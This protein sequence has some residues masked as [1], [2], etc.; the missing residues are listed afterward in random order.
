MISIVII[1]VATALTLSPATGARRDSR[2]STPRTS[3]H[4]F[5]V[6]DMLAM[7]RISDPQVSPDGG[8]IVFVRRTTDLKANRGRTDLWLVNTGGTGLRRFTSDPSG[9][10][11]PRWSPDGKS[12]LFISTR[13]G[14]SQVW[15]IPADGGEAEQVTDEP[16]DVESL[17]VS[18]D[19]THIA[20]SMQVF[21]DAP[22]IEATKQRLDEIA[23][24]SST[25]RLY[26][27]LFVRHWDTWKDGRRAHI[28][29]MPLASVQRSVSEPQA[30][31]RGLHDVMKGMDA[32]C[33]TKP[34]GGPEDYT[35]TP[36]SRFIVFTARDVGSA[37]AWSTDFDLYVAP[38][39]GSAKPRCLTDA[40]RAWDANPVFSPD[41]KKL[42]YLA[43]VKPGY[44]SDRF[45]IML[46]DWPAGTR[47][48][49]TEDWDRSSG[50][51]TFSPGGKTI[52]T[53]ANNLGQRSLFSV[54]VATG[55]VKTIVRDGTVRS[56]AMVR[57]ADPTAGGRIIFGLDHLQSPV[58][59][60][61]VTPDGGDLSAITGINAEKL[62]A[63]RMGEPEQFTFSG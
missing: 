53:T 22:T 24:Q 20:F 40:N 46:M 30:P 56:P 21:P 9:D 54:N 29:V 32:D 50:S 10:S 37:E 60:Y 19:G 42:A 34:F 27:R 26:D 17:A 25:G 63:A 28:F 58:E 14:S 48:T 7:D 45:R 55:V 15:R 51:I 57:T 8:T 62:A 47:R 38:C 16:L 59:L 18:P 43:M 49:L 4:P 35:F 31:A 44:E 3:T 11:N 5:S 12:V 2:T 39:D 61:S 33:P 13:S 23:E 36:D 52:Y 6:H 1:A 41:G